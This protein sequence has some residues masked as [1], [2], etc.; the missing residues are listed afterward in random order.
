M[1]SESGTLMLGRT[2]SDGATRSTLARRSFSR[3]LI[4]P[5]P[6]SNSHLRSA[7]LAELGNAWWLLCNSSPPIHPPHGVRLVAVSVVSKLRSEEHTSEL[8]SLMRISSA[9]F[10]LKQ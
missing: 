2:S 9:V 8:Q 5:Q 1:V 4:T 6:M 3:P 10:C 7:N